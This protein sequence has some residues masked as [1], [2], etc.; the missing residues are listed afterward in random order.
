MGILEILITIT[1]VMLK[2]A[3]T[4]IGYDCRSQIET[5]RTIYLIDIGDCDIKDVGEITY[6]NIALLN[7][8]EFV[9]TDSIKCK[10]EIKRKIK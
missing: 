10:V 8:N 9:Y 3:D 7:L 2:P 5:I 1:I 4:T 6:P